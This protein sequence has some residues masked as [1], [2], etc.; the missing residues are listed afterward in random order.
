LLAILSEIAGNAVHRMRLHEQTELHVKR[1]SSLR[2]VDM[3]ITSSLDLRITLDILLEQVTGQLQVDAA[4]VLLYR[5]QA[6][7]LEFSAGRGWRTSSY[8]RT[9]MRLDEGQAARVAFERKM[10]YISDLSAA[11][12]GAWGSTLVKEEGFISYIG[13][14][15]IAKGSVK[16]VLELFHRTNLSPDTEWLEFLETLASQ[17]AIAIDDTQLFSHLQRSNADL[18]V[19]YDTTIEGWARA[20]EL[21][22]RETEGHTRRVTEITLELSRSMGVFGEDRLVHI[23]RGALLH[24]IGKMAIPDHILFKHSLLNEEEWEIMRMHP[25]YAYDMLSRI[26]YLQPALA[27]PLYHHERWDGTGYPKGLKGEE[28]PIEARIFAV[29]DVWDALTIRRPYREA[30]SSEKARDYIRYNS[31]T[32]FDPQ[33]VEAFMKLLE[34]N[35]FQGD[36]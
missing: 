36:A 25:T 5:E 20:L 13:V 14:P 34:A 19:A 33:V 3:T 11:E 9:R 22:D 10:I 8:R 1:L 17:A 23:R 18:T 16:G 2:M 6:H 28:I 31:G 12:N 21:R 32:H 35:A 30:W 29:V 7:M 4:D 26:A 24:D 15:L 27:I